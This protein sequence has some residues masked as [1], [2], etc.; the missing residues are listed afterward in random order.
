MLGCDY[1]E[2]IRGVG[3]KKAV[4]VAP[5]PRPAPP[6]TGD[7]RQF[8]RKYKNIETAVKSLDKAKYPVPDD[9][10][11]VGARALFKTPEIADPE[12]VSVRGIA[13]ASPASD[14]VCGPVQVGGAGRAGRGRLSGQGEGVQVRGAPARG[15]VLG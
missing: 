2:S 7:A 13:C 1:C 14:E 6:L 12:S 11:F 10:D 15:G 5:R 3:P 8:I 9:W 4:E